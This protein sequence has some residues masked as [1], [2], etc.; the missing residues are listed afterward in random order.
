[1]KKVILL[2]STIAVG[3]MLFSFTQ[4]TNEKNLITIRVYEGCKTCYAV[5]KLVVSGDG[6]EKIT[7]LENWA[8]K[9]PESTTNLEMI[10][11]TLNKYYVDG[12][13]IATSSAVVSAGQEI[14]TYVLIKE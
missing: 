13:K 12:Y 9:A 5:A 1:M 7:A 3:L 2:L 11:Y 4:H 6:P 14:T 10:R 8:T